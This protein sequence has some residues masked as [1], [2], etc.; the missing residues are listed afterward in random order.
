MFTSYK[1]VIRKFGR[2]PIMTINKETIYE[3]LYTHDKQQDN[4]AKQE[5]IYKDSK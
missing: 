5:N 4:Q 2:N 1:N 3:L